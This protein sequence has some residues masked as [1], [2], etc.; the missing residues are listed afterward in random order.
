M[1]KGDTPKKGN[2]GKVSKEISVKDAAVCPYLIVV[3]KL[4][5]LYSTTQ[6]RPLRQDKIGSPSP[7]EYFN[8]APFRYFFRKGNAKAKSEGPWFES[9]TDDL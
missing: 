4:C 8:L 5:L 9:R 3:Y 1:Q 7:S 2:A 6:I